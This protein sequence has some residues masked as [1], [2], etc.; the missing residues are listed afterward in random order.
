M[1]KKLCSRFIVPLRKQHELSEWINIADLAVLFRTWCFLFF[2]VTVAVAEHYSLSELYHCVSYVCPVCCKWK[3]A[4]KGRCEYYYTFECPADHLPLTKKTHT[5]TV[6]D[7]DWNSSIQLGLWSIKII[8]K[9]IEYNQCF[10]KIHTRLPFNG[11]INGYYTLLQC[12]L[13]MVVQC[14]T[15]VCE[16][17]TIAS[18]ITKKNA[19]E[20]EFKIQYASSTNYPLSFLFLHTQTNWILNFFSFL[21]FSHE[22]HENDSHRRRIE[23]FYWKLFGVECRCRMRRGLQMIRLHLHCTFYVEMYS[24]FCSVGGGWGQQKTR[25]LFSLDRI[26]FTEFT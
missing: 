17:T 21:F 16:H 1:G 9:P 26:L 7:T 8:C 15:F 25:E 24:Q 11:A 22:I 6:D 2:R 19:V 14:S 13:C 12:V 23:R 20:N 5:D 4:T 18:C 10:E 3:E